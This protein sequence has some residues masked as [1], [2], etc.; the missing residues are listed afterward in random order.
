MTA[1][2]PAV[3]GQNLVA[4][5]EVYWS[6]ARGQQAHVECC[7]IDSDECLWA[8]RTLDLTAERVLVTVLVAVAVHVDAVV[9]SWVLTVAS[10]PLAD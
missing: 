6:V 8:P 1:E 9:R 10:I 2:I 5:S 7:L 4:R 3:H